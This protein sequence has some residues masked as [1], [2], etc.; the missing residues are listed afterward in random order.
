MVNGQELR[1]NAPADDRPS[2]EEVAPPDKLLTLAE[3]EAMA[4]RHNPTLAAAAARMQV[5][6]GRQIQAGLY[7]NPVVG[8]HATEVGNLGTAGQQGA[9]ISQRV[10]TAG[11]IGLDQ[12]VA[13]QRVD[14]SHFRFHAQEQR[15]LSD[16]RVRFQD[17]RIAQRRIDLVKELAS[18]GD[19]VEQ[20]T[21]KLV[22]GRQATENDL[23]QAQIRADEIRNLLDKARNRH[24]EAWRRLAA[25][26][27]LPAMRVVPLDREVDGELPGYDWDRCYS[28]VMAGNPALGAARARVGW[29]RT[30]I[31]RA[32]REPI[33]NFDV[34]VSHRH[35]NVTRSN[36]TNIQVGVPLPLFN[37]NQ[38]NT[39]SATAEWIA[40]S[41]EVK[42]LELDLQDRLAVAFRRYSDAR[43]QSDRYRQRILPRAERSLLLMK[44]G[45]DKGASSIP[46]APDGQADF[47]SRQTVL[48]RCVAGVSHFRSRYRWSTLGQ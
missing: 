40:A 28:M 7:P 10:V 34:S 24:W 11:K 35:H 38:G 41:N 16:V 8:Y 43:Q 15:V 21:A 27:G 4:F 1:R 30:A 37:R 31:E 45:Y 47:A 3:L 39:R 29:A 13:R 33:P 19:Q 20:A 48:S 46:D 18:I 22:E 9:F 44:R 25:V 6:R 36:I 17:A 26:V 5:A 2:A 14:E 12:A 42:R 23:L 32:R